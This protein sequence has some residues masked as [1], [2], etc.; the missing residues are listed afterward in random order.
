M[1]YYRTDQLFAVRKGPYK[2]HL[3]TRTGYSPAGPEKHDPPLLFQ[4]END[5]GEKIDVAAEHSEVIADIL[6]EVDLHEQSLVRGTPQ[7]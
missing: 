1:F 4:V 7:Y 5:P 6:P 2:A 3:F